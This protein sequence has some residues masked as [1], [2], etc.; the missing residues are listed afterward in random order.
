M[1]ETAENLLRPLRE[2]DEQNNARLC[3]T[4]ECILQSD[5]DLTVAAEKLFLHKNTV[6]YRKNKIIDILGVNP[7]KMPY[8][9]NFMLASLLIEN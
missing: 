4:L 8:L 2:Y 6:L 7:F 5:M 3:K 9:L 1:L